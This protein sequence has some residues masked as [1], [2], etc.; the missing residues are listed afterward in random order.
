LVCL[1]QNECVPRPLPSESA[2]QV[3]L[4]DPVS[5][6]RDVRLRV[7]VPV[8]L[9]MG[10]DDPTDDRAGALLVLRVHGASFVLSRSASTSCLASSPERGFLV[11]VAT[12]AYATPG[13]RLRRFQLP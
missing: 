9:A 7:P 12:T 5:V 1:P 3:G 10:R 6:H 8:R 2:C 4:A 13:S 11:A